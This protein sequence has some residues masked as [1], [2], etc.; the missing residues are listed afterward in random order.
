[1]KN[2]FLKVASRLFFDL[3]KFMHTYQNDLRVKLSEDI[4]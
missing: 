1:M 4:A 2:P 3:E